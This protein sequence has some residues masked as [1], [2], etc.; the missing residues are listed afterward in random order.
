[1]LEAL[2]AQQLVER[3]LAACVNLLPVEQKGI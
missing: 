3:K 2:L 1:M